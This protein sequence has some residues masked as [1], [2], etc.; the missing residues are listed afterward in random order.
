MIICIV[1][2]TGVGKTKMS[3]ALAKKYNAIIINCDATQVYKELNIGSAKATP[4]E[5]EG[6]PHYLLDCKEINEDYTVY[7]YQIDSRK[8]IEENRNRNIIIVGGTGLYL[9]A[10][11]Y[12]YRFEKEDKANDYKELKNEDI[13]KLCVKKN[14][15]L[16]IHPN[17]RRRLI[18]LLNKQSV[19]QVE[20]KPI[21]KHIIIGLTTSRDNLYNIVNERV[22]K[23][24]EEGLIDEARNFYDKKIYTKPLLNAIV[25]KEL[26]KYF[27]GDIT[28]EEAIDTIKKNSR[29]YAKRHYTF[30]NNQLDVNWFE[31]NYNDFGKTIK[32]VEE[33]I[34]EN[35]DAKSW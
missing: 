5:R 19:E 10:A 12:D 18:R 4:E 35:Y 9:K 7:D 29:H 1:G 16:N 34:K 17:N 8:I 3:V 26:Y 31:V 21:Y 20:P 32:E 24:V 2:P 11:L 13:Y 15:N 30:F 28:L 23:M 27:S 22:D 25:Y 33:F 14:P 6:V